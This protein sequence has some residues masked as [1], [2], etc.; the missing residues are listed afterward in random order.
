[1]KKRLPTIQ[2]DSAQDSF[3]DVIANLVGV[4]IILVMLV[5]AKATRD[6]L[7]S[8]GQL[9]PAVVTADVVPSPAPVDESLIDDLK[10]ARSQALAARNELEKIATQ[11]VRIRQEAHQ[12][13]ANRV[14]L[15]MHRSVIEDDIAQRR[16]KLDADKQKEF[17]VQRRIGEIQIKLD[18]LTQQQLGLLSGPETVEELES[19]P[20]PLA[21]T[22]DGES[23]HLRLKNGLVSVVPFNE[24]IAEVQRHADDIGRRLQTS[25]QVVDTFGPIDGYRIRM[26]VIR[27]A[28]PSSIGGPRA[29]QLTRSTFDQL[30]EILPTS[31]SIGQNVEQALMPGG[32]LHQYLQSH[33]RQAPTVVVWLYTDSFDDFRLLKR[34]LWEMGFSFA[35]RPLQPGTNIGASP[36]GTKAAAQ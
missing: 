19:V 25:N 33:R 11:L 13:D 17:D 14:T 7:K 6:V 15:A 29:G 27:V 24:L 3:L 4:I 2:E 21:R 16:D 26:T 23:I 32:S 35:A 31:E 10:Q 28:D 5:G 9:F 18:Q 8:T 20:T 36:H 1:M 12:F 34:T 30:A 22:V